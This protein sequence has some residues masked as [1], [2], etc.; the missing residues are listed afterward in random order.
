MIEDTA[1][2]ERL[3]R[4]QRVALIAGAAGLVLLLVGLLFSP[5]AHLFQGYLFGYLFWMAI[6]VGCIPL[7]MIH[8]LFGG[9]WGAV[10]LRVLE[11]GM[12]TL[13]LMALL[14]IPVLIGLPY[15]HVWANH[16]YLAMPE[17]HA[18][19][20]MVHL[21]EAYLNVPFFIARSVLYFVIWAALAYFLSRWS[22]RQDQSG[23][24][25]LVNN[26]RRLSG[27]GMVFLVLSVTFAAF[28]W[29]MSLTPAWFSGIYGA[30]VGVGWTLEA[31]AFVIVLMALLEGRRPFSGIMNRK[32][33]GDLGNILLALVMIWT[34]LVL[35]QLIIIW[36]ANLP[37]ETPWYLS[38]VEGGWRFVPIALGLLHFALPFLLLL[39]GEIRRSSRALIKIAG[40]LLVMRFVDLYWL[41][42]PAFERPGFPVHWQD[43]VAP[44]GIGGL[45]LAF[46]IWQLKGRAM[47]PVN[48]PNLREVHEHA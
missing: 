9:A 23:D 43:F 46:F 18:I 2:R 16:D 14:F 33:F 45:W 29:L 4:V 41:I 24:P 6:T 42:V 34:Y 10:I 8:Y 38:R 7:A 12:R 3:D 11:A 5:A 36:S 26:L 37:E 27:A 21:K 31:F 17:H 13:P 32:L 47:L 35:S 25:G 40:L 39:S 19:R 1:L 22:S 15:T 30:M 28:D 48:N 44:L 20:H